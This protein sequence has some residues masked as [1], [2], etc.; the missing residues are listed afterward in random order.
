MGKCCSKEEENCMMMFGHEFVYDNRRTEFNRYIIYEN[1]KFLGDI[2][3][4]NSKTIQKENIFP[5][6]I[7]D[8]TNINY[9]FFIQTP[10]PFLGLMCTSKRKGKNNHVLITDRDRIDELF[11]DYRYFKEN[12]YKRESVDCIYTEKLYYNMIND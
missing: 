7:Y 8:M 9:L 11:E 10:D 1:F 3:Y 6:V 4:E 2:F 5:F 12:E